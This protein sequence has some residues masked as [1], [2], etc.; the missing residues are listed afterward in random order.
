[1]A[2]REQGARPG[3]G[4]AAPARAGDWAALLAVAELASLPNHR[5]GIVCTWGAHAARR[6][7]WR[8]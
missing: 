7:S 3:G 5:L 8:G 2:E 6:R 1:V 4:T